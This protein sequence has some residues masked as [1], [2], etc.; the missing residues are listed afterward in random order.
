MPDGCPTLHPAK[1]ISLR[2]T[3]KPNDR[4]RRLI[5]HLTRFAD[6]VHYAEYKERGWP[7]GS[8]EIESA[9]RYVPQER[10]KIAGACWHPQSVNPMLALRVIRINGWWDDFWQW[11]AQER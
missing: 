1:P 9:H 2:W 7:I 11:H 10:L 6:A 8:G 4:L 5:A 3:P